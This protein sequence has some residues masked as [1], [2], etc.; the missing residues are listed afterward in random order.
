MLHSPCTPPATTANFT[1]INQWPTEQDCLFRRSL[2]R[3]CNSL[4]HIIQ[5]VVLSLALIVMTLSLALCAGDLSSPRSGSCKHRVRSHWYIA[6][7][8]ET[9]GH[10][11]GGQ[12]AGSHRGFDP[13]GPCWRLGGVFSVTATRRRSTQRGARGEVGSGKPV[14]AH[15]ECL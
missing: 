15:F 2:L 6:S 10:T 7:R 11:S 3:V 8:S 5:S 1:S 13:V 4:G 14:S 12:R 9:T